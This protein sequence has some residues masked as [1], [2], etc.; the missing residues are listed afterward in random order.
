MIDDPSIQAYL[1]GRLFAVAGA[2]RDRGKY[3]NRVLRVYMQ[4]DL[5]VFPVNPHADE[6][7]GLVA[8]PD[9]ASLPETPHGVSIVTPP[10]VTEQIVDQAIE[11]GIRHLWMQPGAQSNRAIERA[12]AAGIN[13]I[14]SGPCVLVVLGYRQ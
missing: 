6:V 8:W 10:E 7:E 3:G 2:S 5:R 11:L 9:L 4:N 1:D 12:E 14:H 13:L